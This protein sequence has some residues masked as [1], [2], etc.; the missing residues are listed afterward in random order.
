MNVVT[1]KL[2]PKKA[3]AASTLSPG[4]NKTN[5]VRSNINDILTHVFPTSGPLIQKGMTEKKI[6]SIIETVFANSKAKMYDFEA[7]AECARAK[8][9]INRMYEYLK[10][11]KYEVVDSWFSEDFQFLG[12]KHEKTVHLLVKSSDHYKA[13]QFKYKAPE[14]R[15]SARTDIYKPE[16]SFDLY[17]LQTAAEKRLAKLGQPLNIPVFGA[18]FYIKGSN[19]KKGVF[20]T[21]FEERSGWNITEIN[22]TPAM[23]AKL[24]A[25][26]K[27]ALPDPKGAPCKVS[28]CRDC[29]MNDVCHLE[30][31]PRKLMPMPE[32]EKKVINEIRLTKAQSEFVRFNDGVCRCIACAGTG[33]TTIITLRTL[34]LIEEGCPP[35]CILMITFTEKAKAEMKDRL[36]QYAEGNALQ[37]INLDVDK[38][39][40]ETF[41]SWGQSILDTYY[42]MLG[43][44]EPPKVVDDVLKKD[45]IIRLLDQHRTL[46]LDYRN[47]FLSLKTAQGAVTTMVKVLDT[48]KANHVQTETETAKHLPPDLR[49]RAA[50]IL[51]MY[52]EYNQ[53]LVA[54]NAIDY[55]DQL[56]LI[57]ELQNMGVLRNLPY[58]HIVVDE[59][60]DSNLNQI[61]LILQIRK[62]NKQVR[63]LAVVGDDMQAI[64]GF[65]NATPENI[66]NF[67]KYFTDVKD[68]CLEDNFRSETPIIAMANTILR[69]ES[70]VSKQIRCHRQEAGI[71][72]V[73]KSF[74]K[75][76]DEIKF[77]IAVARKLLRKGVKASDIA[78]MARTRA[79]LIHI[80][81]QFSD[82]N[83]PTMLKVPEIVGDSPYV[84]A[85]IALAC[86]LMDSTD[87][88]DLALY[89][90]SIGMDPMDVKAVEQFGKD[91]TATV[92]GLNEAEK[93]LTFY[94]LTKPHT[95][96]YIAESFME[97]LKNRQPHTLYE[98]C[99]YCVKYQKYGV[100]ETHAT[101]NEET[102]SIN[103]ITVHSAK[104]LEWD[105]VFLSIKKF[106]TDPE[107]RRLLYVGVTRAKKRL[108]ITHD[109]QQYLLVGLL[110]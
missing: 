43:F 79:E 82:A 78:I 49:P 17:A 38:I 89:C 47:P 80:Q 31:T 36:R 90:K 70:L 91:L 28:A 21:Y 42:A 30:F 86:F 101:S 74:T 95:E 51:Q 15:Y 83:I 57:L 34:A 87:L 67:D 22:F 63:S 81:E 68:I 58:R 75:E 23:A 12:K 104:G 14:V 29:I 50:E 24:E 72:P 60:Q 107:E 99:D 19:D 25:F 52:N 8:I 3:Y 105:N 109:P 45:I 102:E 100:K 54:A 56:R 4:I 97:S 59:F 69:K 32:R 71:D 66:V 46:P 11:F 40:V 2:C 6:D 10:G 110:Q 27:D 1:A 103:L 41:N 96:D 55:E 64:Y 44:S 13:I 7:D 18:I 62:Q 88:L 9:L 85:I 39:V 77:F 53:E 106:H 98:L 65:R 93:I 35:E 84:K 73:I 61:D 108:M 76:D 26:Y 94:D 20:A 37:G 16:N 5:T 48:L 33:K 92:A